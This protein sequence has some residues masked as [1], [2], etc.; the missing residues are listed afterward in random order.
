VLTT[1]SPTR[2]AWRGKARSCGWRRFRA[3]TQRSTARRAGA[4]HHRLL[5]HC[6]PAWFL[7]GAPWVEVPP[8]RRPEARSTARRLNSASAAARPQCCQGCVQTCVSQVGPCR[9]S[10]I[11][12]RRFVGGSADWWRSS[13]TALRWTSGKTNPFTPGRR[14]GVCLS[15]QYGKTH[16]TVSTSLRCSLAWRL[17]WRCVWIWPN[18]MGVHPR[19]RAHTHATLRVGR[20]GER[21]SG[22]TPRMPLA[23][24]ATDAGHR[25]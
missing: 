11:R 2:A 9:L 23:T 19:A 3:G 25:G 10:M 12:F 6:R 1:N 4:V 7:S 16:S 8:S 21:S 14:T 5:R 20:D 13:T 18:D 17:S 22:A 24:T 15:P